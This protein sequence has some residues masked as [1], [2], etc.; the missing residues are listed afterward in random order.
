MLSSSKL[1]FEKGIKARIRTA[2][3]NKP[4]PTNFTLAGLYLS[5]CNPPISCLRKYIA[6]VLGKPFISNF[7]FHNYLERNGQMW[8]QD[9]LKLLGY[10]SKLKSPFILAGTF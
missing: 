8:K 10:R 3:T 5:S 6:W 9:S 4:H 7:F 1:E 2:S